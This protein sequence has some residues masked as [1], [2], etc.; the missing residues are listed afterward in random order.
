M[1]LLDVMDAQD[2]CPSLQQGRYGRG[3]LKTAGRI[4]GAG[5]GAREALDR[6]ST[7]LNSSHW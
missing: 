2:L 5:H 3:P 1:I 6:K 4:L 7:R